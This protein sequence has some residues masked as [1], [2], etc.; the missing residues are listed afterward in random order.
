MRVTRVDTSALRPGRPSSSGDTWTRL[1]AVAVTIGVLSLAV[2]LRIERVGVGLS[3]LVFAGR[4]SLD[5]AGLDAPPE[6]TIAEAGQGYDGAVFYFMALD[7]FSTE[8]V[9]GLREPGYRHQRILFPLVAGLLNQASSVSVLVTLLA[10]NLLAAAVMTWLA[11]GLALD[12]GR[13]PLLG[14]LAGLS[15]P[16]IVGTLYDTSEPMALTLMVGGI[17]ATIRGKPVLVALLLSAAV[18]TRETT[19]VAPLGILAWQL[20]SVLTGHKALRNV[21]LA[22]LVPVAVFALWQAVLAGI[23]GGPPAIQ[24]GAGRLGLPV[25]DVV[26]SLVSST[27]DPRIQA[28]S[29]VREVWWVGR[30]LLAVTVTIAGAVILKDWFGRHR[31][32]ADSPIPFVY[33]VA[34]LPPLLAGPWLWPQQYARSAGE[35]LIVSALVLL[36]HRGLLSRVGWYTLML[37]SAVVIMA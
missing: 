21:A 19:V 36:A 18:L 1:L 27:P 28:P 29:P 10:V 37:L 23:W 20:V 31:P 6:L 13:S 5:A 12:W 11:S 26:Q 34:A 35:W 22:A 25:L 15:P 7:P 8:A 9:A 17:A 30:I 3:S 32:V 33:G 2:L 24:G 16:M 4:R 14:V